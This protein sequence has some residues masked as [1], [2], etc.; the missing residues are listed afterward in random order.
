MTLPFSRR[1]TQ[2]DLFGVRWICPLFSA[3]FVTMSRMQTGQRNSL[4]CPNCRKLISKDEEQCPY[5]GIANPASWYRN[6][7]LMRGL[8]FAD[9]IK[10]ITY[11]TVGMFIVSLL[12]NLGGTGRSLSPFGFLSPDSGSL[13]TLGASG[14]LPVYGYGMWWSVVSANYLHGGLLHILFNMMAL[15]QIGPVSI[16]EYGP[17]RMFAIYT[18]TG[19][20]GF[21]VSVFAGVAFTIGASG[22]VCGLIGAMLYYGKSRGG[23]Y[24]KEIYQQTSGWI[25]GLMLFGFFFPAINNWAHG[26]GLVAGIALGYVLGYVERRPE[27]Y[28]HKALAAGCAVLTVGALLF[29]LLRAVLSF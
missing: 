23:A 24:G 10:L 4:L 13:F 15:R 28:W 8:S 20:F 29:G 25:V 21:V 27:R 7:A 18:L 6:N 2:D 1:D 12:L 22:A 3:L 14:R 16:Q 17:Y 26:G 11:V 19:V 5:C 9:P